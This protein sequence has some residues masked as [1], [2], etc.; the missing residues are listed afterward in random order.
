MFEIFDN[1]WWLMFPIFWGLLFP[2]WNSFMRYKRTQSKID[3]IKTYAASGKEPPS[4]LLDSLD[5][6]AEKS[7]WSG[8]TASSGKT[9]GGMTFLVVLLMG[10]AGVF[11][12]VGYSDMLDVGKPE[13]FYFIA[14]IL[15]AVGFAFLVSAMFGGKSDRKAD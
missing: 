6:A 10:L 3:L 1:Y 2:M 14:M 11:G 4:G 13:A 12:Y 9:R 15:S 5:E 7:D 8:D